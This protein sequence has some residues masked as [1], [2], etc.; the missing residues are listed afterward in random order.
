MRKLIGCLALV[1]ISLAGPAGAEKLGLQVQAGQIMGIKVGQQAL[2]AQGVGGFY[3]QQYVASSGANLLTNS[4]FAKLPQPLP[5]GFAL[6]DKEL[7]NGKPTLVVTMPEDKDDSSGEL[8]YRAA[9]KP[10]HTYIFRYAHKG[11]GVA[12]ELAPMFHWR[13]YD[14]K[15]QFVLPQTNTE[16][17]CGT[18]DWK[19][20][21]QAVTI[22]DGVSTLEIMFHHPLGRGRTWLSEP[23]LTEAAGQAAE[24]VP[25]QWSYGEDGCLH[26]VGLIPGTEVRV[27][28]R[29]QEGEEAVGFET[30]VAAPSGWLL[31]HPQAF[32][33]SFRLPITATGWKWGDYVRGERTIEAGKDYRYYHL[34]GMR[35]MRLASWFPMAA[36][37]GSQQGLALAAPLTPATYNRFSY[38]SRGALQAEFDLGLAS[39]A[40]KPSAGAMEATHLN[41]SL[42]HYPP[43][44]GYRAALAAYYKHYPQLFA[45]APKEG[46]WWQGDNTEDLQPH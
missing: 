9:V 2:A 27:M 21:T 45:G 26:F 6:D 42:L 8:V 10:G 33:L 46:G 44:W 29:A 13:Q 17:P 40:E 1:V 32:V 18:Y 12:G 15:D 14:A 41:F 5:K 19:E 20:E 28:A 11:S 37:S 34:V 4:D 25:G 3:V 31:A 7:R 30:V 22:G 35:Q 24:A 23:T 38:G 16:L 36:I 39:R 43:A